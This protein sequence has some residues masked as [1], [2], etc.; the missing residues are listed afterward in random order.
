V[1]A[2]VI[3]A[4]QQALRRGRCERLRANLVRD[5]GM[6]CG[7][8]MEVFV[9]YVQRQARLFIVGAGHVA[10]ALA[11]MAAAADFDVAVFDDREQM[12]ANPA[13]SQVRVDA[14]DVDELEPALS[15][16]TES[17]FVVIVTR[18]HARDERILASALDR[19][20]RY[21]GMI[22][23]RRKVLAVIRRIL[24][25]RRQMGLAPPDLSRVHAPIGLDL[26]GRT[27]GEIAVSVVAEL[28]ARRHGGSGR[29]LTIANAIEIDADT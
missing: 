24:H 26:G 28:V 12:L 29:S 6:C 23:S 2:Q 25:R 8:T 22:G 18:D 11:P 9:E 3:A 10:Q 19:P 21:L 17:D 16:L 14:R 5:L 20:H 27:P 15:G 13:F 1:E 4:C 7:G